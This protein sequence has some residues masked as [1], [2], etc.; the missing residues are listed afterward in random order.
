MGRAARLRGAG[1]RWRRALALAPA[2]LLLLAAAPEPSAEAVLAE[3]P[4]ERARRLRE[5]RV[6]VREET[7][8]EPGHFVTAL[9][10]FERRREEVLRLLRAAERQTEYRPS[11]ESVETVEELPDG[12]VVEQRMRLFFGEIVYRLRY[13][14]EPERGRIE[15]R[16]APG[17][18]HDLRRL[19]GFWELHAFE[20]HPGRTLGRFGSSV[21]A[22]AALPGFVQER[23]TR[24]SVRRYVGNLRR[25][26]DSGGSWRP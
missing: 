9:A 17:F 7:S 18:D 14:V 12:R 15:W 20:E 8:G 2:A 26:V 21:D 3:L 23:L 11:L 13:R 6:L 5:E 10:L 25:W 1:A 4:P 19:E 22:T 24:R 16:L